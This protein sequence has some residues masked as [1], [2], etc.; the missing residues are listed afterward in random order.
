[1]GKQEPESSVLLFG[2]VLGAFATFMRLFSL[3]IGNCGHVS[4]DLGASYTLQPLSGSNCSGFSFAQ[5][6]RSLELAW[7]LPTFSPA[8]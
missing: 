2:V 6:P 3:F 4:N 1:L 8:V 5:L 7:M